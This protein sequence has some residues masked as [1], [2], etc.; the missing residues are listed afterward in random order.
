MDIRISHACPS[1]G[2]PVEMH[3]SDRL[4]SC[5][6]CGVQNYIVE[7][8]LFRFVLPDKIPDHIEKEAI[9]Y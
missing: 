8:D 4:S 9:I 5:A 7:N 3:E 6:F 1:C 2:A